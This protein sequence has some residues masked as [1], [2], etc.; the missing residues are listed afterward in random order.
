M[1][2]RAGSLL[3]VISLLI[4]CAII[5]SGCAK[6]YPVPDP[7]PGLYNIAMVMG[8]SH[9]DGGLSQAQ[10]EGLVYVQQNVPAVRTAYVE[11]VYEYSDTVPLFRELAQKGFRFIIGTELGY[12]ES[13]EQVAKEYPEIIFINV[14][15]LQSSEPNYSTL[16]GALENM[17][18]LAG[19][20]AGARVRQ[21]GYNR[22]G[23]MATFPIPEQFRLINATALG[24]EVTCPECIMDI[25]W[26]N[27]WRDPDLEKIT[28]SSLFDSGAQVVF[29]STD[30]QTVTEVAQT[31]G[32][33]KWGVTLG[34][35]GSC[36]E[37]C[38]TATY[39]NWGPV[40][41]EIVKVVRENP[42]LSEAI[43]FDADSNGMGLFGFMAGE[44]PTSG[45]A[46][47]PEDVI[48][49][50]QTILNEMLSGNF[51]Y[52]DIFRGEIRDNQGK[53]IVP[54]GERLSA[55]DVEQ[56]PPGD[57]DE[58]CTYPECIYWYAEGINA[59]LPDIGR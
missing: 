27:T 43:Y 31:K 40:Y 13:M 44:E 41:A 14:L 24:I 8:G 37:S 11:N 26:L 9:D 32:E 42:S 17:S 34:W 21:D 50:V 18:Y 56:F 19:M 1:K 6:S 47:L 49:N 54:A 48:L 39:W 29:S 4:I 46:S 51:G 30:T 57:P 35:K 58:R 20:L 36:Q 15:G 52:L 2:M 28:A 45:V 38:L 3:G 5:L 33:G 23:Y 53:I 7:Q 25:S 59:E 55:S 22:L 10:Y 16:Y 12:A